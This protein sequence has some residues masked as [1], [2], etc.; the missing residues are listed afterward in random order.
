MSTLSIRI[1]VRTRRHR[2]C[3]GPVPRTIRLRFPTRLRFGLVLPTGQRCCAAAATIAWQTAA[4]AAS[5][6]SGSISTPRARSMAADA[7]SAPST[8]CRR[9]SG[10]SR[11]GCT[12]AVAAYRMNDGHARYAIT[13]GEDLSECLCYDCLSALECRVA[14]TRT[15]RCWDADSGHVSTAFRDPARNS[16]MRATAE[17]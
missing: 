1:D 2:S 10:T 12:S 7:A 15:S 5:S 14:R 8:A 17:S 3:P 13:D 11:R 9:M 16:A 6:T 4:I